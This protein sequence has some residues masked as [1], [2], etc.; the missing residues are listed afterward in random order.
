MRSLLGVYTV[1]DGEEFPI[2][3]GLAGKLRIRDELDQ[4]MVLDVEV[5][6]GKP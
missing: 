2:K 4:K 3:S 6:W 1:M 5:E